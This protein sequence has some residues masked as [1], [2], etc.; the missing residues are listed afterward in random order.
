[1]TMLDTGLQPQ[2]QTQPWLSVLIPVYNVEPYLTA[3]VKSV[4]EQSVDDAAGVE[5]LL[6]DDRSTDGSA[7]LM[8]DLAE[9]WPGRLLLLQH[10]ANAGLSAA[11][12]TLIDHARGDYLWFLD[13]DDKLLPGA[14]D[15]LRRIVQRHAVDVV[16]CDFRVWRK[17]ERLK[18]VL[19]GERHRATFDG[20]S[21]G[22]QPGGD[23]LAAGLLMTGQLHAWSK[24]S[25][26]ALWAG[27]LRFPVGRYFEDMATMPLLA[28]RAQTF[29][30]A[31][32]AWVAYRQREGSILA[33]TDVRKASHQSAA[34]ADFAADCG[35]QPASAPLRF[36]LAHQSARNL[37]GALRSLQRMAGDAPLAVRQAAADRFRADF[38]RQSPLTLAALR[39]QYL[40]RGWWLRALRLGRWYAWRPR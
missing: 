4:V 5:V 22:P 40:R 8:Q 30:Y 1:M 15:G 23:A 19:R 21:G 17:K 20:A 37:T 7:Q 12:N 35:A 26:R 32:R 27:G 24:I 25:R 36:A 2:T 14:I 11:R 13:S 28:R 3:C 34:L 9:R 33:S 38:D 31:P 39:R 6:L 16:L 18:H 29:Y 10:D